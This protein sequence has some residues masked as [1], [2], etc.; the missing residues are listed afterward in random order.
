MKAGFN[1]EGLEHIGSFRIYIFFDPND[2]HKL[3]ETTWVHNI[4]F[5]N[6]YYRI[7]LSNEKCIYIICARNLATPVIIVTIS[8]KIKKTTTNEL[9]SHKVLLPNPISHILKL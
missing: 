2:T 9:S 7:F 1:I 3:P 8:K 5:D 6:T 4:H